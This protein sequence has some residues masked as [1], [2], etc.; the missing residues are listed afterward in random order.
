MAAVLASAPSASEAQRISGTLLDLDTDQPIQ[1]GLVMLYETD[2]D[3]IAQAISDAQGRFSVTSPDPGS[4]F[5]VAA[6]LGYEETRA[7]IF[8][9]GPGGEMQVEY[10][11]PSEPIPMEAMLVSVGRPVV[12]HHLVR[13]G[14]VR[15]LQR[16]VGNFITP[17]DIERSPARSTE[18]LFERI[19]SMRVGTARSAVGGLNL[20]MPHLGETIQF[21]TPAGL[22]SPR[23]YVDG[24]PARLDPRS[25]V[26]LSHHVPITDVEAIEVYQ[27]AAE[28]PVEYAPGTQDLSDTELTGCG[29]ILVWTKRGPAAGQ[30]PLMGRGDPG[31]S[32]VFGLP[33]V[34]EV[35]PP[36]VRGEAIRLELTPEG[37]VTGGIDSPWR[38]TFQMTDGERL[39]AVDERT[40]RPVAVP[41]ESVSVLQVSRRK[42]AIHTLWRA[43]LGGA[44]IGIGSW[45]FLE[46]LCSF[47]C[48]EAAGPQ[49]V[50]PAVAVGLIGGGLI[51]LQGP[52]MQWVRTSPSELAGDRGA[53]GGS[54]G[55]SAEEDVGFHVTRGPVAGSFGVGWRLS[56]R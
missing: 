28:I 21:M 52:G 25:G 47:A 1:F 33:E 30:R 43:G 50:G 40:G 49:T 51:G 22:C 55:G 8:E 31:V 24:R 45:G 29:M 17:Y 38:G 5:M 23:V 56:I 3:S 48:G 9:L 15:R 11:L 2:G 54:A 39:V 35:G 16:G 32:G 13:N 42:G 41:I 19:P 4:F 14:F 44:L 27:R 53:A 12:D 34:D 36:P 46:V 6:A 26:T 20:P 37:A 18:A 10:R 7:G